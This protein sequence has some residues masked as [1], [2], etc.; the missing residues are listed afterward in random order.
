MQLPGVNQ[1]LLRKEDDTEDDSEDESEDD[2][3]EWEEVY[4]YSKTFE[5]FCGE[6]SHLQQYKD[7]QYFMCWGGCPEGGYITNKNET[8]IVN[9]KWGEPFTVEAINGKI[10]I[11]ESSY[12]KL[13]IIK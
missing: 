12:T 4:M 9:R 3:E 5:P 8:Y 10:D 7:F 13:R 1:N 11:Q 6:H 2:E